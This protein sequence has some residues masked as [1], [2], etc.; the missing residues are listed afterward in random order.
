MESACWR[1]DERRRHTEAA[2]RASESA[3]A[4]Q[5]RDTGGYGDVTPLALRGADGCPRQSALPSSFAD[6]QDHDGD[7]EDQ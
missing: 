4:L 7:Q 3:I 1:T 2:G 6:E 5:T